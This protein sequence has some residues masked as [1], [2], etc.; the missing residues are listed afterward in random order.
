V[1]QI[2][3]A[4]GVAKTT[5]Y[6]RWA[7][8][9]DLAVDAWVDA[10][11]PLPTPDGEWHA[12]LIDA[13]SWLADR[14]RDPSMHRL[15]QGLLSEAAYDPALREQLW[16]RIRTPYE[17]VLVA[18][19]GVK[20]ADADLAFDVVVG[21]ILHHASMNGSVSPEMVDAVAALAAELLLPPG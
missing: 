14:I 19:W 6:R 1:D 7:T 3:A 17:D 9:S 18:R 15:Q 13:V 5:I 21:S 8:K 2:A 10:L 11:G 12:G 16:A 4:A 20:R